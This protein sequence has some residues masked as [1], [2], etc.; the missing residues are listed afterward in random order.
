MGKTVSGTREGKSGGSTKAREADTEARSEDIVMYCPYCRRYRRM[1]VRDYKSYC[2]EC[3]KVVT[4]AG[5]P[6]DWKV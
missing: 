2:C 5:P 3:R 4:Y 1:R 6:L